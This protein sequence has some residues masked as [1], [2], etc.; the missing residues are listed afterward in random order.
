MACP[1]VVIVAVAVMDLREAGMG[2]VQEEAVMAH[3]VAAV[4]MGP[5]QTEEVMH[6]VAMAGP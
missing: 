1:Q 2:L 5:L 4:A 3:Q 6:H